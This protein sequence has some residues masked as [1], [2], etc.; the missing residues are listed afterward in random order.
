MDN[1]QL[2]DEDVAIRVQQGE[3]ELFRLLM[4]R[5]QAKL[6]RY[7]H[8]FLN[9]QADIEDL[10]QE[11]FIKAYTNL[12]SFDATRRFSPWL[13]RIAHN[14]F[15]NELRQKWRQV[16]LPFELDVLL[17]FLSARGKT[18]DSINQQELKS[19]MDKSLGALDP[20]YREPMLLYFYE[21]L[22]YKTIAE[23]LQLPTSTVGIRLRRGKEILKKIINKIDKTYVPT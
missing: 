16:I 8:K 15:V 10:V 23:I 22:D 17:P 12:K 18:D 20:K 4:E 14:E 6:L 21:E 1:T 19:M 5:Y 11:V 7:G 13:Y 3:V 2:T 9:S